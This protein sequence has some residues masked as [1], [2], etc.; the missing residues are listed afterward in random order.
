[1]RLPM[2]SVRVFIPASRIHCATSLFAR[3]M[4]REAKVRV[5]LPGSSEIFASASMRCMI[6]SEALIL[7]AAIRG[8][9]PRRTKEGHM[10]ARAC[11][12]YGELHRD[13]IKKPDLRQCGSFGC[14]V[15]PDK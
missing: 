11:V 12:S 7:T 8:V 3:Y 5:I 13:P 15:I 14:E 9:R 6:L 4:A 1:M 2:A 10:V